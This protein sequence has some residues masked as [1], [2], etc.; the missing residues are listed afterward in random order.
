MPQRDANLPGAPCWIDLFTTAPDKAEEFY[1]ELFGWKAES[2]GEEYGGY[3]NFS[4]D[5]QRVAGCMK[6][7]G[8]TGAPDA[9]SV[10]LVT[11]N[12][13]AT[14]AA[15]ATNGGQIIV[16]AMDVME[17]GTMAVLADPG[18]AAIGAWQP[19]T[20]SGFEIVAE[21]GAPAWFELHTRSYDDA[22]AFYRTVFGWAT[23]V[24]SNTPEL[25][26]T[27]L[28]EGDA[29]VAGIMDASDLLPEGAPSGWT[30]YFDVEDADASL[31][32]LSRLGG[33]V[34]MAAHDTPYGRI[35]HVADA[36]GAHFSL[37]SH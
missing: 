33:S 31:T 4:K 2:A 7:D 1:G 15:A 24:M 12:T 5:G 10:Y 25:R 6:N 16:P 34:V 27:T 18:Q 36:T 26:Y 14:V 19:G 17:L 20:F 23:H 3:I 8:S 29:S 21:P 28:G 37:L 13:K 32:T 11:D 30:V 22:V 35:A 9:W